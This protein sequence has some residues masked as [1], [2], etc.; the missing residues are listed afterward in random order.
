MSSHRSQETKNSF[1]KLLPAPHNPITRP[2]YHSI[3]YGARTLI[4][5]PEIGS[6]AVSFQEVLS[7]KKI[8]LKGQDIYVYNLSLTVA[9]KSQ[10]CS[11]KSTLSLSISL[12]QLAVLPFFGF[13]LVFGTFLCIIPINRFNVRP[14]FS[15]RSTFRNWFSLLLFR[16]DFC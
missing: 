7:A 14:I 15:M 16:V 8:A 11:R 3:H 6:D 12:A 10:F 4:C 9:H 2:L 5:L 13:L 1:Q